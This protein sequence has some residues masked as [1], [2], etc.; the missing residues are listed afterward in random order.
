VPAGAYHAQLKLPAD[1][2]LPVEVVALA[3]AN[4]S[5]LAAPA[6]RQ[7]S[8]ETALQFE[9]AR[10]WIEAPAR[11]ERRSYAATARAFGVDDS[12]I[13]DLATRRDW[14]SRSILWDRTRVLKAAHQAAE[15]Q[16]HAA[17]SH[18][19]LSQDLVDQCQFVIRQ[20]G[21]LLEGPIDLETLKIW[22]ELASGASKILE[23]AQKAARLALGQ[24]DSHQSIHITK[25]ETKNERAEVYACMTDQEFDLHCACEQNAK[26]RL[27]WPEEKLEA[28]K[29][30]KA[31]ERLARQ[32]GAMALPAEAA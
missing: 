16:A 25:T 21:E 32:R 1:A 17:V 18:V 8:G 14:L 4:P 13:R 30:E 23:K 26:E 24:A 10:H 27:E 22:Q 28:W 6:T 29:R 11:G 5:A 31:T 9:R 12:T 7:L 20:C 3:E 2:G 19:S 15:L